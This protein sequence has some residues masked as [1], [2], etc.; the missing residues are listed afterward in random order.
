MHVEVPMASGGWTQGP[1]GKSPASR[2]DEIVYLMGYLYIFKK[3]CVH[4]YIY[5]IITKIL[6]K[7][8]NNNN[9]KNIIISIIFISISIIVINFIIIII[10][11]IITSIIIII[12]LIIIMIIFIIVINIVFLLSSSVLLFLF[13]Y[14]IYVYIYIPL[15]QLDMMSGFG[16]CNIFEKK[17]SNMMVSKAILHSNWPFQGNPKKQFQTQM[18]VSWNRVYLQFIHF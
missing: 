13:S 7:N 8:K 1:Q 5:I 4:I 6:I 10:V 16:T 9:N 18:E 3:A 17:S 11:T 14:Y 15:R 2:E 12:I